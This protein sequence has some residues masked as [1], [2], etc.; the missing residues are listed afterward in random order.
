M[1]ADC[2]GAFVTGAWH[3]GKGSNPRK[4]SISDAEMKERWDAIDWSAREREANLDD[5]A[6]WD[7]A[8]KHFP[9]QNRKADESL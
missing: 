5:D 2:C 6:V 4:P 1:G 8:R 3:G 7:E 9:N